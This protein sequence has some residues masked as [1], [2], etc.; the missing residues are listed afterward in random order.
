[1]SRTDFDAFDKYLTECVANAY[2][3][4]PK[5]LTAQSIP[6]RPAMEFR[7]EYMQVPYVDDA[8]AK[9]EYTTLQYERWGMRV[10][11]GKVVTY[12]CPSTN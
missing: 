6:K 8:Q 9:A 12:I 7:S 10:L 3:I 2:R 1:M 11:G 5:L 4:D